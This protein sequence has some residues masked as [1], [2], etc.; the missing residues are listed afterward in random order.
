MKNEEKRVDLAAI[1]RNLHMFRLRRGL[2]PKDLSELAKIPADEINKIESGKLLPTYHQTF[3]FAYLLDT[4]LEELSGYGKSTK[5]LKREEI[6]KENERL[7]QENERLKQMLTAAGLAN[8]IPQSNETLKSNMT[9]AQTGMAAP[10]KSTP[11]QVNSTE[12]VARNVTTNAARNVTTNVAANDATNADET[13]EKNNQPTDDLSKALQDLKLGTQGVKEHS[14]T[15]AQCI[16]Q[17]ALQQQALAHVT[18]TMQSKETKSSQ[19]KGTVNQTNANIPFGKR[20]EQARRN[21][22]KTYK[23]VADAL[24]IENRQYMLI[25][26]GKNAP[27]DNLYKKI[28]EYFGF[29]M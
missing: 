16:S 11:A 9:M 21:K 15:G 13:A 24:G 2:Q 25:E 4:S 19:A 17:D 1:G 23:Q 27:D 7:K 14:H 5:Q 12:N 3:V 18:K 29:D 10:P 28:C 6:E 20:M 26:W 8:S 22:K